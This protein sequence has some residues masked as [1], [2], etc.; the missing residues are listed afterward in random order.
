MLGYL[1]KFEE[2]T[3][4]SFKSFNFLPFFLYAVPRGLQDLSSPTK[5]RTHVPCSASA[6]S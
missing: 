4:S 3:A 2:M 1:L 5:D 6:E